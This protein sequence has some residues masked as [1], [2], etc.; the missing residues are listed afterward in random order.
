MAHDLLAAVDELHAYH[1]SPVILLPTAW[2]A[3]TPLAS[4]LTWTNC[5]F[6]STPIGDIPDDKK[7][8]YA[9]VVQPGIVDF[10]TC[11]YLAYIGKAAGS[12]GFR[13]RYRKYK[14]ELGKPSSR[15]PRIHRMVNRW[16]GHLWFWYAEVADSLIEPL[17][18]NLIRTFHPPMNTEYP[19]EISAAKKAF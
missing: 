5:P 2:A 11:N 15:R 3:W 4:T 14:D 7:G 18:D 19:A 16:Y 10:P 1:F 9:F 12:S 13:D 17:E 6:S 8:V